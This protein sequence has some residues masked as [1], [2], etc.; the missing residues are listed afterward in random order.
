MRVFRKIALAAGALILLAGKLV[1][2][3]SFEQSVARLRSGFKAIDSLETMMTIHYY[4]SGTTTTRQVERVEI[5]RAS[6]AYW[7]KT[8]SVEFLLN[9]RCMVSI[10]HGEKNIYYLA[11]VTNNFAGLQAIPDSLFA[12]HYT[13]TESAQRGNVLHYR[14]ANIQNKQDLTHVDVDIDLAVTHMTRLAYHYA[15]GYRIEVVTHRFDLHPSFDA[16]AFSEMRYIT[17]QGGVI[18]PAPSYKRYTCVMDDTR[19]DH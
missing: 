17:K 10:D 6:S 13:V 4:D 8:G 18:R 5:R 12:K 1:C 3:Q 11:A 7:Y 16:A 15:N 19:S 9:D 14:L 2:A